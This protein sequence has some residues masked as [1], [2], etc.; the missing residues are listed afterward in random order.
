MGERAGDLGAVLDGAALVIDRVGGGR[1]RRRDG[2]EGRIVE[3]GADERRL[4]IRDPHGGGRDRAQYD[5]GIGAGVA[6]HG[7]ANRSPDDGDV[8]LGP[9]GHA[10]IGV[11]GVGGRIVDLEFDDELT[12]GERELTGSGDDVGDRNR[13]LPVGTG[14][15]GPGLGGDQGGHAVGGGRPVAQVAAETRPVLDLVGADQTGAFSDAGEHGAEVVV[16]GEICGAKEL[17]VALLIGVVL[18]AVMFLIVLIWQRNIHLAIVL[19]GAIPFVVTVSKTIGGTVPVLL[20]KTG[21]DPAMASGPIVTTVVDLVGFFT[22]LMLAT[23]MI[24]KLL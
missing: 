11:A 19:G 23:L 24:E 18:G 17:L 12:V 3:G 5:A 16:A 6:I 21:V 14:D 8:H 20:K 2:R 1:G 15:H 10:Q 13:A 4:G 9:R 22:V 7:D